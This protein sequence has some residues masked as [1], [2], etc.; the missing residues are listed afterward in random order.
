MPL[1]WNEV[2]KRAIEFSK[3]WESESSEKAE[4]K[5]FWDEFFG[6]F[7]IS[8]RRIASFEKPVLLLDESTGYIDLFWKG[9]LVVEHKS[10]GKNLDKA[11]SQALKYFH[12][13]DENE[14]PK[15]VLV[16]DFNRFRL[17]NLEENTEQNFFLNELHKHIHLFGFILG[18]KKQVYKDEDPVNIQ[19]AALMGKLHDALK[20]DGYEGHKLEVFLVRI[21][22][23]LFADDTGIFQ[24]GY[25]EY[26]L[27]NKT[28]VDGSD[29]GNQI[30]HIF[31]ILNTFEDNRQKNI[32]E[33]I[34]TFPYIN[35]DLYKENLE[36]PSFDSDMRNLLLECC[37]FDWSKISPA[38]FGSLFQSV[39]DKEKRRD[40]GAHYTS[41]KN[42]MKVIKGLFLD[43][44]YEEFNKCKSNKNK[45]KQYHDKICSLKFLDPA[46]GCGNFL[47]IAYRELRLLEIKIL[48]DIYRFQ[49]KEILEDGQQGETREFDVQMRFEAKDISKIDVDCMYGIEIEE[50]PS[51]IAEVA[52]WLI[53]HQ[54]NTKL[55]VEFGEYFARIPLKKSPHIHNK[56]ALHLNWNE[57]ISKEQC[58]YILGNPPF[59][60]K[61]LQSKEQKK[62]MEAIFINVSGSGIMD[63]VTAWYIKAAQ[64][65]QNTSIKAAFVSTNS[66]SQG[67]QVGLLWNELLN[68]YKIKIHFAHRT[69]KWDNEAK[70]KAH[71]YVIIIGFANYD[72]DHKRLYYYDTLNSEAMEVITKN[73]NPYLIDFDDVIILNRTKPLSDVPEM[74]KGSQPTDDGNFLFTD[75]EKIEFIK[76]EPNARKFIKPFI[77]A[78]EFLH[79]EKRWCLWLQ[80]ITPSEIKSM[81]EVLQRVENVREFRLKSSKQATVKQ[82]EIAY[83]FTERRQPK[84]NYILIPSHTS[85]NRKY[86]PIAYLTKDDILNNSCLSLPDANL[87]HFGILTSL[88]HNTWM[89]QVCGRLESRYRY[90]NKLVYNNYPWPD[91][92]SDKNI[93]QV[94]EDAQLVLNV[95]KEFPNSSLADLYDPRS[96]P[97]KLVDAHNK[98]DKAVDLCYRPQAFQNELSRLEFLF[99]L[100]KKYTE[101]LLTEEKKKKLI[102]LLKIDE[103]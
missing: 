83:L 14:L 55:S 96:M 10:K 100:Y 7:G 102:N 69:F 91:K 46:C 25:F 47:I 87:Y 33:D 97:K 65:I 54:M 86:I 8:R 77:S 24:K 82:A 17:Y 79:N 92:P 44:L 37:S 43:E 73:I 40:L 16:S 60:G 76:K 70:G 30:A 63:Y 15:Y 98:I 62:E 88:M 18:Y 13:L 94:E 12:G 49:R 51:R 41:E 53:D 28:K 101:P 99:D 38:I 2:K 21:L 27:K 52:M 71:V 32:D 80:D 81:P 56:N 26:Y 22:F 72:T 5:T 93:K 66:I 85:E 42:I 1:N 9:V 58:S 36:I 64:Y 45:L 75:Y 20:E 95:R 35:G 68:K 89:R 39:M 84:G 4:A 6:V 57:V 23:C 11:Y 67:E 19:A 31:Q 48:K 3:E 90:S 78:R 103:F 74:Y 61:Q 50:F 34:N 29:L 59:G